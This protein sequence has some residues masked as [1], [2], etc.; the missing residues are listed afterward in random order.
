MSLLFGYS[1]GLGTV[2]SDLD[3]NNNKIINLPNPATGSEPVT[4]S[5]ADTHYS[6]GGSS[7]GDKGDKGDKGSP[8][9]QGN[10]GYKGDKGSLGR[11]GNKGDKGDK[12]SPGRQ[13]NKGDK[14]G[15]GDKGDQGS[16][17]RQGDKGDKGSPGR[18]GNKGDKGDKSD[19]GSPGR[20]G[21]K[22]DKGDKGSP[23]RQN[24]GRFRFEPIRALVYIFALDQSECAKRK[25]VNKRSE[26]RTSY[27]RASVPFDNYFYDSRPTDPDK[28]CFFLQF[29][30]PHF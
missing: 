17:G 1:S 15:I 21:N 24:K 6:G 23:G 25:N 16:P 11:Q 10:K 9:R 2:D 8:G 4:K 28:A 27:S 3:M 26:K 13:G 22:G 12:G 20:Q 18:Q 30:R 7:K 29:P 19:Q 5:Y 14:G